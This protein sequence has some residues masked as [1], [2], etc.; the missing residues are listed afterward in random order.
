MTGSM[1]RASLMAASMGLVLTASARADEVVVQGDRLQGTVITVTKKAVVFETKY[2]KGNVEI[3]IETVESLKTE[4]EY[5]FRHGDDAT[6]EG[7]ILGVEHGVVLVGA[8]GSDP[9]RVPVGDIQLVQSRMEIEES[10]IAAAKGKL[11]Y[12]SGH[13]DLGFSTTQSTVDATQVGAGLGARRTK[14]PSRFS[15]DSGFAYG[16]QKKRGE[17]QTKLTDLL[18]GDVRQEYDLA[19]RVFAYGDGYMEYNAIQRLSLRGIPEAGLGYKFWKADGEDT[20]DFFAGTVGASWV[21]EK[22]FGGDD[23]DY[24]AFAF[25]LQASVPL[26]YGAKLT[27]SARYFP[28]VSDFE[29]DFLIKSEA[30]L[31]VPMYKQ[32]ALKFSVADDYDNTPAPDPSFNYLNMIVGLSAQL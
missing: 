30:A 1:C 2:G 8:E 29:H 11:R 26:P 9:S 31:T 14:G 27:G 22:F 21:Y 12:W 4:K 23:R 20:T 3:P 18:W 24:Y 16:I 7:R 5:V 17:P 6:A 10:P 15:L 19:E 13:V 25:G 32:L 28:S